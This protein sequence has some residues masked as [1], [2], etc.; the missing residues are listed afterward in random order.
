MSFIVLMLDHTI[1][2]AT[3]QQHPTFLQLPELRHSDEVVVHS[4]NF[5]VSGLP[6]GT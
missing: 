1:I 2:G 5:L 3:L 4:W 6:S